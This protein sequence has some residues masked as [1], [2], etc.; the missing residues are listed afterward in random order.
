MLQKRMSTQISRRVK[1]FD[2]TANSNERG[3]RMHGWQKDCTKN[4]HMTDFK[5]K[6]HR[7]T[8]WWSPRGRGLTRQGY[9]VR[10]SRK[11]VCGASIKKSS[12]NNGNGRQKSR[13]SRSHKA[14]LTGPVEKKN[15]PTGG[16]S[17]GAQAIVTACGE[18][19]L[20]KKS[21]RREVQ[22]PEQRLSRMYKTL[23]RYRNIPDKKTA[24]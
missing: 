8:L 21:T 2:G 11:T 5:K 20:A 15:E 9:N 22:K 3:R 23:G 12:K 4:L 10:R 16:S 6:N 13:G 7:G 19:P 24:P 18:K 14:L 1:Q 17:K